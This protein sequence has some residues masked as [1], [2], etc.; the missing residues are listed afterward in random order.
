MT[1]DANAPPRATTRRDSIR[2]LGTVTAT[3]AAFPVASGATPEAPRTI[4][5]FTCANIDGNGVPAMT[6]ID[7]FSRRCLNVGHIWALSSRKQDSRT[8]IEVPQEL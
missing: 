3:A 8:A 2:A 6:A 7:D 5:D 4:T 1:P